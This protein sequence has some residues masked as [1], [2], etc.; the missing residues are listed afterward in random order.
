MI[1]FALSLMALGA[2]AP[3]PKP[4]AV[5]PPPPAV[6]IGKS[7]VRIYPLPPQV[8]ISNQF[9]VTVGGKNVPV[10]FTKV[11]ADHENWSWEIS[12]HPSSLARFEARGPVEVSIEAR[13]SVKDVRILPASAGVRPRVSGNRIMFGLNKSANLIVEVND[14][15]NEALH[16]FVGKLEEP[17]D[18]PG[19]ALY[20]G[21]GLHEV[22]ELK[23]TDD[24][25]VVY[26]DGSAVVRGRFVSNDLNGVRILGPGVI[27][28]SLT[29]RD[30]D[31]GHLI[32]INGARDVRIEG[33]TLLDNPTWNI[34]LS[35]SRG[36]VF[37]DVK[38]LAA[39]ATSD[40]FD[41]VNSSDIHIDRCFVR[42]FDDAVALKGIHEFAFPSLPVENVRV[43]HSVF[44]CDNA[45]GGPFAIGYETVAPIIRNLVIEDCDVTFCRMLLRLLVADPGGIRDVYLRRLHV[46][47]PRAREP[48]RFLIGRDHFTQ[49]Y[50]T[51]RKA[52]GAIENVRFEQVAFET[53]EWAPS[54][55]QGSTDNASIRGVI[56]ED[57]MINGVPLTEDSAKIERKAHVHGVRFTRTGKR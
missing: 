22:G 38:I 13:V 5:P 36:A 20:F 11:Q 56:F 16:L 18:R 23:L 57:C 29:R 19:R 7:R 28:G 43:T 8:P 55:F 51:D 12:G 52:D 40:G 10:L 39:R 35:G 3:S 41:I 46:R 53:A 26:L 31:A 9:A 24:T 17:K 42:N 2:T 49:W 27:D 33:P 47:M 4:Q 30:A 54:L 37:R 32:R 50:Q 45:W 44:H 25:K 48:L 1:H 14:R 6:A 15:P 34:V 21:P